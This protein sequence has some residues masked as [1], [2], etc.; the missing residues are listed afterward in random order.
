[1]NEQTE[2]EYLRRE[3]E[4]LLGIIEKML[5]I[6]NPQPQPNFDVIPYWFPSQNMKSTC[7]QPK[8]YS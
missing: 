2:I 5:K 8:M 6:N 1:M 7:V 3:N 4:R